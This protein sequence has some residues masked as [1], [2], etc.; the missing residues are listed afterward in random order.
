MIGIHFQWISFL[1]PIGMM[2]FEERSSVRRK[3]PG[4]M[5]RPMGM[6]GRMMMLGLLLCLLGLGCWQVSV[7]HGKGW[8]SS[9]QG[10]WA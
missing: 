3:R 5:Y 6:L 2:R 1:I 4:G 10:R 9:V 8:E 7:G